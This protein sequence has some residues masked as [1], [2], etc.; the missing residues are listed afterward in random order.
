MNQYDL[1]L[2]EQTANLPPEMRE[3]HRRMSVRE[4]WR[5]SQGRWHFEQMRKAVDEAPEP[6]TRK[7]QR[8]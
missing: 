8:G 1:P 5:R 3:V 2:S 4:H 7:E 6:V